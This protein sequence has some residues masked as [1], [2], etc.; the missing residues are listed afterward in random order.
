[1]PASGSRASLRRRCRI[2]L[3]SGFYRG[4]PARRHS[5][6][7][8]LPCARSGPVVRRL[9]CAVLCEVGE[10]WMTP[11]GYGADR[12][13]LFDARQDPH[14][15]ATVDTG[16][17]VDA[18]H[19]LEALGPGHRTATLGG[20]AVV[21]GRGWCRRGR[22]MRNSAPMLPSLPSARPGR[23]R[24]GRTASAGLGC[25]GACST[26]TCSTARTAAAGSSRAAGDREDPDSPQPGSAAAAQVPGARGGATLACLSCAGRCKHNVPGCNAN[27]SRGGSARHGGAMPQDAGSTPRSRQ[28]PA[29]AKR[30]GPAEPDPRE[31]AGTKR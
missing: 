13:G 28:R 8:R 21:G 5:S 9:E 11:C 15:T 26:S 4:R 25:S 24:P 18:E 20:G 1:M 19:A 23:P 7:R 17:H 27:R 6:G 10:A 29:L 3:V 16:A 14:R 31:G 12:L 30:H 2:V 22:P